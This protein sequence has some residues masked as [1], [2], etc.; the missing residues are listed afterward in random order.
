MPDDT[1]S[2]SLRHA[3][4]MEAGKYHPKRRTWTWT[5]HLGTQHR[6]SC[7]ATQDAGDKPY[8]VAC[9]ELV[10]AM[11][12]LA[13]ADDKHDLVVHKCRIHSST[14]SRITFASPIA[15]CKQCV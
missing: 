11:R 5:Y 7:G 8:K 10:F 2:N 3:S 13:T 12:E 6:P 1:Q 14:Y 9:E 4:S 15:A